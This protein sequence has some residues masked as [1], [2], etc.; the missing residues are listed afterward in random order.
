[1]HLEW[2]IAAKNVSLKEKTLYIMEKDF[3]LLVSKTL[4]GEATE[5]EKELLEELFKASE[6]DDAMY[7]AIK[8]YWNADVETDK[9]LSRSVEKKIWSRHYRKIRTSN[10]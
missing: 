9:D 1:M 2:G 3:S 8:E 5:K 10:D 4:S 7:H 6:T